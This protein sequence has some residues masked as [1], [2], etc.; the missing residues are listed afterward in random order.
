MANPK[1]LLTGSTGFLGTALVAEFVRRGVKPRC[2]VRNTSGTSG[3]DAAGLEKA[4]GDLSDVQSLAEA[5]SGV[6]TVVHAA[7]ITGSSDPAENRNVNFEG[8]RNL[9][10]ACRDRDVRR[11][12]V[13]SSISAD[14]ARRG[15]YGDTKLMADNLFLSSG[16]DVTIIRPTLIIGRGGKHIDSIKRFAQMLP[17]IVP[18]IGDGHYKVQPVG[19]DDVAR[20]V[21]AAAV[22]KP[23]LRFYYAAG[24]DRMTFNEMLMRI[25]SR[26]GIQKHLFHTPYLPTYAG[27]S[28]LGK[29]VKKLPVNAAQVSTLC[30][31]AVCPID[32]TERDFQMSFEPFDRVLDKVLA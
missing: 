31:D 25:L 28:I 9:I 21:V 1:I 10:D 26:L 12:V 15:A 2:L 11:A 18:V 27:L 32:E 5:L 24:R 13:V 8:S 20:C 14:V 6:D 3:I 29:I 22:Q 23:A 17:L 30:Q 19:V 7:A 16:M 4:V